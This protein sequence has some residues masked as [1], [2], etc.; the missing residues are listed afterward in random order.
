MRNEDIAAGIVSRS[1][2]RHHKVVT[3]TD[4][5]PFQDRGGEM[6][7]QVFAKNGCPIT[8]GD[9]SRVTGWSQLRSRLIGIPATGK[10]GQEI[11][12]PTIYFSD[13][14]TFAQ[15]YFPMLS[16]HP[17][18][19]KKED[20]QEHGEPTHCLDTIRLCCMAHTVIKDKIEPIESKINRAI[21]NNKPTVRSIVRQEGH[22]FF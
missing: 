11:R 22:R 14:C 8:R 1:E 5:L 20:A 16:R 21:K 13:R 12:I 10:D 7:P 9:T 3:L 19:T 17:S 6:V 15:D 2:I 4:S 18:E